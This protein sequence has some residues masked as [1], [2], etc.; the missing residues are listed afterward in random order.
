VI[1]SRLLDPCGAAYEALFDIPFAR[2]AQLRGCGLATPLVNQ[3]GGAVHQLRVVLTIALALVALAT[4]VNGSA[5]PPVQIKGV[6]I[7]FPFD[8]PDLS[9]ACGFEVT[10]EISG[11]ANVTLFLDASGSIVR[12]IDSFP[13]TRVT[14][15]GN[16]KS[17]SFP[18]AFASK[19][20]TFY[21]EGASIGAPAIVKV[22]G[23]LGQVRGLGA[24]A[25]QDIFT[26]TVVDFAPEGFP[27]TEFG[28]LL[29]SHGNREAREAVAAAVCA[30]L[31]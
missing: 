25:G 4:A 12:E 2:A 29:V 28:D 10:G 8:D 1:A 19:F 5:K 31:G 13:S 9:Q 30:E 21:P 14:F 18:G 23:L 16:G 15:S 22:T 17:F 3:E 27:L 6:D 7:S 26:A 20:Q 24:D 11:R